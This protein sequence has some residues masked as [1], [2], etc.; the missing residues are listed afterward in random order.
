MKQLE[1]RSVYE[2]PQKNIGRSE[3][4]KSVEKVSAPY[5]ACQKLQK[6]VKHD[7]WKARHFQEIQIKGEIKFRNQ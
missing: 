6:V 2:V 3:M 7:P 1:E 4:R 5:R